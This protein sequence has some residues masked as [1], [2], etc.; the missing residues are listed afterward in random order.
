MVIKCVLS[1]AQKREMLYLQLIMLLYI[2]TGY[3]FL[4]VIGGVC[5]CVWG[6]GFDVLLPLYSAI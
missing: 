1:G 4:I 6:G 2:I 3:V 5:M